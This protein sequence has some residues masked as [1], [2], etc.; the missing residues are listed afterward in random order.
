MVSGESCLPTSNLLFS[1]IAAFWL[2][3]IT[4]VVVRG[5]GNMTLPAKTM[6]IAIALIVTGLVG[7][8]GTSALAAYGIGRSRSPGAAQ[9]RRRCWWAASDIAMAFNP[10]LWTDLLTD[11][12]EAVS[13]TVAYLRIIGP[14]YGFFGLGRALYFCSQGLDSLIFPVLGTVVR[15]LILDAFDALTQEVLFGVVAATM[16]T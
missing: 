10:S 11:D 1:R 16:T 2:F 12:A 8:L 14:F 6:T 3:N 15:S 7:W 9:L 13:S 4:A 5:G